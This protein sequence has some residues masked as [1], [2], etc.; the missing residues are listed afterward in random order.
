MKKVA[1]F[2][3]ALLAGTI[4]SAEISVG[5]DG[6][7]LVNIV[8]KDYTKTEYDSALGMDD[9]TDSPDSVSSAEFVGAL[10]FSGNTE[11]EV[12]GFNLDLE[13]TVTGTDLFGT[14]TDDEGNT[15]V[16]SNLALSDEAKVWWKPA[17]WFLGQVGMIEVDDLAVR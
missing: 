5:A 4:V 3:A 13:Y 7:G 14:E 8:D 10:H 2:A 1:V 17:D 12:L 16:T 6:H 15:V 11:D 9:E